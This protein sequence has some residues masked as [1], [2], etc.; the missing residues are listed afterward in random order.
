MI[1]RIGDRFE[2]LAGG[3]DDADPKIGTVGIFVGAVTIDAGVVTALW[4]AFPDEPCQSGYSLEQL[5]A[6]R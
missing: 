6:V 3:P 5:K 2:I 1:H 4:L